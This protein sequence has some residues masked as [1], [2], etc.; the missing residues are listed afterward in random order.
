MSLTKESIRR[1]L[2][3]VRH[4][5]THS[6]LVTSEA[7]KKVAVCDGLVSVTIAAGGISEGARQTFKEVI[8]GAV[9]RGAKADGED[10]AEIHVDFIDAPVGKAPAPPPAAKA[11][12]SE[13]PGPVQEQVAALPGV[14]YV[15]AVGAG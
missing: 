9:T 7:V 8:A 11:T 14:K 5:L 3:S 4:P 13:N 6:D 12:G 2:S 1:Y 15:I 10:L